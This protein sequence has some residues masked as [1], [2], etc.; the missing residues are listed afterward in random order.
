[1][2]KAAFPDLNYYLEKLYEGINRQDYAELA[3]GMVPLIKEELQKH[4]KQYT[5]T[6][7][8]KVGYDSIMESVLRHMDE[9]EEYYQNFH[10]NKPRIARKVAL[11]AH[12]SIRKQI[13]ALEQLSKR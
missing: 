10:N 12:A 9:L 2:S 5:G 11:E 8:D 13:D 4:Q 7:V 3:M 1:M 6:G